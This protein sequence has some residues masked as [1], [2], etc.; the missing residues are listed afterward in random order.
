MPTYDYYCPNCHKS[1]SKIVKY[2]ERDSINCEFCKNVCKRGIPANDE[3]ITVMETG[4]RYHGIKTPRGLNEMIKK[5]HEQHFI[6]TDAKERR[7][8]HGHREA[9]ES[10]AVSADGKRFKKPLDDK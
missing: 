6:E 1:F 3:P 2:D 8:K 5:R 9:V 7:E 10:G 4:S